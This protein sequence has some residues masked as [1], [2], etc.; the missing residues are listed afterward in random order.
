MLQ[1]L[2]LEGTKQR[3]RRIAATKA[4]LVIRMTAAI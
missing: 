4:F 2:I 3:L 1:N